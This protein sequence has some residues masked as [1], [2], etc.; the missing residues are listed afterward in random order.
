MTRRAY[1][2]PA[3]ERSEWLCYVPLRLLYAFG[4]K[5]LPMKTL[6][7]V[8]SRASFGGPRGGRNRHGRGGRSRNGRR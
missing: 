4:Y 8:W 2:P 3:I 6:P 5:V 7:P 1:K